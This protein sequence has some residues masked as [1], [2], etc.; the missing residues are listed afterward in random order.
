[1]RRIG[2]F[3]CAVY[4]YDGSDGW[5][6]ADAFTGDADTFDGLPVS[7]QLVGRRFED[8]KIVAILEYIEKEIG[9]PF[10]RFL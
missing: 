8:E 5:V 7:L 2:S 3:V 4:T 9:L 10:A 6:S 1:M